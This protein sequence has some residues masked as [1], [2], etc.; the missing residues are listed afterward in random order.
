[1]ARASA[2]DIGGGACRGPWFVAQ[3]LAASAGYRVNI[4]ERS[5]ATRPRLYKSAP[6][7]TPLDLTFD[8]FARLFRSNAA[9]AFTARSRARLA[10]G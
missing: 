7:R 5:G 1:V 8:N 10:L 4:S 2:P 3:K 6:L 9:Q